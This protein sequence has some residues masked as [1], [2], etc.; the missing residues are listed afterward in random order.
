MSR[1]TAS[2]TTL[3]LVVTLS[4]TPLP[5]S[6]PAGPAALLA[7]DT[8]EVGVGSRVRV[9]APRYG[10]WST[11]ALVRDVGAGGVFLDFGDGATLRVEAAAVERLDVSVGRGDRRRLG[12][13]I[14]AGAG[15]A[16][17]ALT[18]FASGDDPPCDP[19]RLSGSGGGGF[20]ALG[21]ALAAALAHA[22]FE[23]CQSARS[24]GREKA[25]TRAV[26]YGLAG[27]VMGALI[28][29][30]IDVERWTEVDV[31]SATFTVQPTV[32]GSGAG[33]VVS[34]PARSP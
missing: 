34:L 9:D 25:K 3:A 23:A 22:A 15:A 24:T 6:S 27:G 14:G 33:L 10:L 12:W 7:Q 8:P 2:S 20:S 16:V 11:I 19:P 5:E 21:D 32:A 4:M 17:G 28:G 31:G 29:R 13:V 1:C 26:L 18:G 30:S